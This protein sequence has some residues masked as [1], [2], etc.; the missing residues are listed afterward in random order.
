MRA[1]IYV[2][3]PRGRPCI[4]SKSCRLQAA[5]SGSQS[6]FVQFSRCQ[7]NRRWLGR[8]GNSSGGVGGCLLC[9]FYAVCCVCRFLFPSGATMNRICGDLSW[10]DLDNLGIVTLDSNIIL[11]TINWSLRSICFALFWGINNSVCDVCP[12]RRE[13]HTSFLYFWLI[14]SCAYHFFH[15]ANFITL[16]PGFPVSQILII[17][18]PSEATCEHPDFLSFPRIC[19]SVVTYRK[20]D[21]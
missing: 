11:A 20:C 18:C 9:T 19:S 15:P 17:L 12:S 3:N 4:A 8:A 14:Y 2:E 6:V 7:S 16:T 21:V 13:P 10:E 1:K 5:G